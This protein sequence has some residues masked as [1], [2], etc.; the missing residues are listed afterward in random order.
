MSGAPSNPA[1]TVGSVIID[2]GGQI[3]SKLDAINASIQALIAAEQANGQAIAA[4]QSQV[5]ALASQATVIGAA[6]NAI[7]GASKIASA[8]IAALY[9]LIFGVPVTIGISIAP[10]A[11]AAQ[12]QNLPSKPG[13]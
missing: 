2:T 3:Y 13:P 12:L 8:E 4:L 10:G 1:P 5:A 9:S 7:Q 6:I 11:V